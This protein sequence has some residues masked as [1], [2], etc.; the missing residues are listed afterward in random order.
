MELKLCPPRYNAHKKCSERVP[1]DCTGDY[2]HHHDD[3]YGDNDDEDED[4]E[5][6]GDDDHDDY[7]DDDDNGGRV[8]KNCTGNLFNN[9]ERH[10]HYTS[11]HYT[12]QCSTHWTLHVR[13]TLDRHYSC[14]VKRICGLLIIGSAR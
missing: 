12:T 2:N 8:P 11:L 10:G 5:G 9:D 13:Y 4:D 7:D 3:D 6:D 1:K 14:F